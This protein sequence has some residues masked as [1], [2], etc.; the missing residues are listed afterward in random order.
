VALN[1]GGDEMDAMVV[2]AEVPRDF[3]SLF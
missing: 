3:N 1:R 2:R